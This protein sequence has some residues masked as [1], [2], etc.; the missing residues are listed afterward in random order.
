MNHC[1]AFSLLEVSIVVAILGLLAG[2]IAT[3][4]WLTRSS[5]LMAIISDAHS[6]ARSVDSFKEKYNQLPGDMP[7][8]YDYWGTECGLNDASTNGCNGDGD[9]VIEVTLSAIENLKGW[10]HLALA[11][12]IMGDYDGIATID[13]GAGVIA[14]NNSPYAKTV[15]G[16]WMYYG[17]TAISATRMPLQLGY[18][19]DGCTQTSVSSAFNITRQEALNIDTKFDDGRPDTGKIICS[20]CGTNYVGTNNR[21]VRDVMLGFNLLK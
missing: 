7:N 19:C 17:D 21:N 11:G 2:A 10:E 12:L 13:A 5:N 8:A 1:R 18:V 16:W 6:Y 4:G 15:N 9:T 3:Y 20:T 14:K